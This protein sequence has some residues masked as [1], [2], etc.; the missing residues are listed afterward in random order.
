MVFTDIRGSLKIVMS[1]ADD[2]NRGSWTTVLRFHSEVIEVHL[3]YLLKPGCICCEMTKD[4]EN[5]EICD[6]LYVI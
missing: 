6:R 3:K 1:V 2:E 4:L 5:E